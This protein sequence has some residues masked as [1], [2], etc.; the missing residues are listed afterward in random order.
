MLYPARC[1]MIT[2]DQSKVL[3]TRLFRFL[4]GHL[5]YG[6]FVRAFD[7][8]K[9][10]S[11]LR[12]VGLPPDCDSTVTASV[13]TEFVKKKKKKNSA[14]NMLFLVMF[15]KTFCFVALCLF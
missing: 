14:Q 6:N 5:V 9:L 11:E 13:R 12:T 4:G 15:L 10:G 8:E 3:K 7:E 1:K 2:V